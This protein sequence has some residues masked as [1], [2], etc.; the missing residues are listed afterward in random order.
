MVFLCEG[1]LGSIG[2]IILERLKL[3]GFLGIRFILLN[4]NE[5]IFELFRNV[6]GIA[7]NLCLRSPVL[8]QKFYSEVVQVFSL[9]PYLD[10]AQEVTILIFNNLASDRFICDSLAV[11]ILGKSG[12][13]FIITSP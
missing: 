2:N 8:V 1:I 5:H 6:V 11:R 12:P 13:D 9:V 3:V 4:I 7:I 10:M